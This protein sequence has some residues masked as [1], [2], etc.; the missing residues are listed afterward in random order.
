MERIM[1]DLRNENECS[2]IRKIFAN[3]DLVTLEE[4][5]DMICELDDK[6]SDLEDKIRDM[7]QDIEDN[8][9]Q[10]DVSEQYGIDD[11]DFM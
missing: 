4:I 9:R 7:E 8:Y 3:K 6:V 1:I 10:I 11:R 2:Q 5:L